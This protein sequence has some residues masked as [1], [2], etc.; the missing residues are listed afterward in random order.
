MSKRKKVV[1]TALSYLQLH[2]CR[3]CG[4]MF[5]R[6]GEALF[7][8]DTRFMIDRCNACKEFKYY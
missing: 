3:Q 7:S 1:G 5:E 2:Q 8:W 4:V 6:K